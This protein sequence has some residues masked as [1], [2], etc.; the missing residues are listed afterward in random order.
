MNRFVT[1]VSAVCLCLALAPASHA[2]GKKKKK[3]SDMG[4]NPLANV[5]SRQPDK[6]LF[7]KAMTAMKKGK[8]DVARLDLQTLLNT[9]PDTEYAMRAKLAVGDTWYK[10]G[11]SAALTQAEQE[12]KDFITF[13]PNT[14]EAAEAQMKVGDI[15]FQQMEKPDRDPQNALHAETEYRQMLQQ[16]PDSPL[17]PRAKQRLRDVQE[18]VAARQ[19]EVGQFYATH[20]NWPATIARMQ[21]V[22]DG[23]PLFSKSDLTLIALGDAYVTQAQLAERLNIAPKIKAELVNA[24]NDRAAEAYNRVVTRYAMAPHVEDAKDRLIAMGR[25][26]PEPTQ[27]QL[28]ESE[29]EEGSRTTVKLKD[30][31]ML[32]VKQGPS[33][34]HAARV[35]EPTLTDLP[36]TTAPEVRTNTVAMFNA[37]AKGEPIAPGPTYGGA[38]AANTASASTEAAP[39]AGSSTGTAVE[40]EAVPSSNSGGNST[41]VEIVNPSANSGAGNNNEAAPATGT[42]TGNEAAPGTGTGAAPEGSAAAA[43]AT[44]YHGYCPS[45]PRRQ[46]CRRARSGQRCEGKRAIQSSGPDRNEGQEGCSSRQEQGIGKQEKEEGSRQAESVLSRFRCTSAKAASSGGLSSS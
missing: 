13:F 31:A 46:A 25:P 20:E 1:Q 14:P 45:S 10:E 29:A 22:A 35:G 26:V 6:E 8:Y 21:T 38:S 2:L 37:A 40:M 9:Y 44:G 34:V 43:P 12:Y 36:Q 7:D 42:G 19:F 28:A 17:I 15:Y 24:Y 27:A 33:T 32:L 30:R 3:Q 39:A 4:S 5:N 23:Y 11:G 16:F 18:V 41:S